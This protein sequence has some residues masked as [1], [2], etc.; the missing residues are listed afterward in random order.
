MSSEYEARYFK[1]SIELTNKQT[2]YVITIANDTIKIIDNNTK[3]EAEMNI[4]PGGANIRL[5][6]DDKNYTTIFPGGI[7][8]VLNGQAKII[9]G[10]N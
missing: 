1:N 6:Q 4:S 2:N 10:D 3:Q 8:L 7:N 5:Y 9:Q